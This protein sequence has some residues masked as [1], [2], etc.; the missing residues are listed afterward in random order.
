[1]V[2][3]ALAEPELFVVRACTSKP[4][5]PNMLLV[6]AINHFYPEEKEDEFSKKLMGLYLH[7]YA[8]DFFLTQLSEL[9]NLRFKG[10]SVKFDYLTLYPT[11][12]KNGENKNLE[13]LAKNFCKLVNLE[14]RQILR[15]N[16][17]IK[18]MH[19]LRTFK[20]R[21]EN[22]QGSVDILED[23]KG[24]NI[25]LLDN[26]TITGISLIDMANLL[27]QKGA[28]NVVGVCLGVS[29][30]NKE[31]DWIDLNKTLKYSRIKQI[32]RSPY[33]SEEKRKAWKKKS[34]QV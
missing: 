5:Y 28:K 32:C 15:R 33:V 7:G 8:E 12:E 6:F 3:I 13:N 14:Y 31:T 30:K 9:Y 18:K 16:R 19:E 25:L 23:V 4:T 22:I 24:K 26:L 17:N 34:T 10:D 11:H 27:I 2:K 21:L 1:M 20:E 29:A